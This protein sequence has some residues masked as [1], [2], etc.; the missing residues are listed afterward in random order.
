MIYQTIPRKLKLEQEQ[1]HH[2]KNEGELGSMEGG[3]VSALLMTPSAWLLF[4]NMHIM[5][6]Y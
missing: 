5:W 3:A 4:S 1:E 6:I 2:K